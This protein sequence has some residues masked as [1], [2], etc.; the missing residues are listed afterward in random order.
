MTDAIS[1]IATPL[2]LAYKSYM[3]E[4]DERDEKV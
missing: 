2:K 3:E 1:S 4:M